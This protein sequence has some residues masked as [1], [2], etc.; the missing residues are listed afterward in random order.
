[1]VWQSKRR[2]FRTMGYKVVNKQIGVRCL[3]GIRILVQG[4]EIIMFYNLIQTLLVSLALMIR[5]PGFPW[6][7]QTSKHHAA[8]PFPWACSAV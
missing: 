3:F 2:V 5:I 4:Y 6:M 8:I 7:F 1:M